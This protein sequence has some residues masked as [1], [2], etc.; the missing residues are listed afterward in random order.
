MIT[1]IFIENQPVDLT[2]DI[3]SLLTFAIDDIKD[4]ASRSTAFSKTIILNLMILFLLYK[5]LLF[6]FLN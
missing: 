1:E 5:A 6:E 2:A 4:F 3:S